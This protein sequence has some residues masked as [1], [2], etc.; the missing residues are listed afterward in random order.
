MMKIEADR[1]ACLSLNKFFF[2]SLR[3]EIGGPTFPVIP[4][5]FMR[6]LHWGWGNG[7][8][9]Q[10]FMGGKME[11]PTRA[12]ARVSRTRGQMQEP[13]TTQLRKDADEVVGENSKEIAKALVEGAKHGNASSARLLVDLADGADWS[14]HSQSVAEF[15]T[16]AVKEWKEEPES[17]QLEITTNPP[18]AKQAL[19]L[20]DGKPQS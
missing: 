14:E 6:S 1:R 5:L 2:K 3:S 10:L 15:L 9:R 4:I 20:T 7:S 12:L 11:R 13:G 8:G 18:K 19:H 16:L 17:V